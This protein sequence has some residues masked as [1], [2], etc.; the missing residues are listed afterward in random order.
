MLDE[1]T[2]PEL[3]EHFK[4]AVNGVEDDRELFVG[5]DKLTRIAKLAGAT[6]SELSPAAAADGHPEQ[7]LAIRGRVLRLALNRAGKPAAPPAAPA[8]PAEPVPATPKKP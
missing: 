8:P 7:S 1:L 3:L 4:A 5:R 2:D 6:L